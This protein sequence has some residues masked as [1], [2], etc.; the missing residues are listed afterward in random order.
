MGLFNFFKKK[1]EKKETQVQGNQ[2]NVNR[3]KDEFIQN[4]SST[5][6]LKFEGEIKSSND[7]S[8]PYLVLTNSITHQSYKG[9][10]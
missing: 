2:I 9:G 6:G 1:E 4:L 10:I 5:Y 8:A 3:L 7:G